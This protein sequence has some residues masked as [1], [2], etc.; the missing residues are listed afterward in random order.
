MKY[1]KYS[2]GFKE[3]ILKKLSQSELSVSKF[4]QQEGMK[5][6]TLYSW[7]KQFK[8]SGF[9]VTKSITPDNW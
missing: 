1:Q 8:T 2:N 4:A 5:L 7:Q 9:S 6:P 3:A